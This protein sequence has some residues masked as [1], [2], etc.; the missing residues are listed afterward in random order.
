V[1][2][3][4]GAF[5][6]WRLLGR[7]DMPP[8][9]AVQFSIVPQGGNLLPA[10]G[11]AL[12]VSPSG[13]H[14][15]F[16]G[17]SSAGSQLVVRGLAELSSRP[18]P[19]TEG[20]RTPFF[21]PDG[22][23]V[24]FVADGKLK[25]VALSG[26][27]PRVL[28]DASDRGAT[29][30]GDNQIYFVASPGDTE[31][32]RIAA[33]GGAPEKL[34]PARN[35]QD[36]QRIRSP[37]L[38]PGGDAVLYTDWRGSVE[39]ARIVVQSLRTGERRILFEQALAPQHANG[40]LVFARSDGGSGSL[41]T[42][43]FDLDRLTAGAPVHAQSGVRLN[44]GGDAQYSLAGNGTLA[45]VPAPP[46]RPRS[47]LW[48]DRSG[49]ASPLSRFRRDYRSPRVSPDGSKIA[50]AILEKDNLDIWIHDIDR[51]VST[52]LTQDRGADSTPVWSRDGHWVIFASVRAG[53]RSL[54]RR[55]ADGAGQDE[56]L[57]QSQADH[58]PEAVSPDGDLL[59]YSERTPTGLAWLL[60]SLTGSQTPRGVNAGV[61]SPDGKF[62]LLAT[63]AS[64]FGEAFVGRFAGGPPVQVSNAGGNQPIWSRN[65]REIVYRS[66]S[67]V[68]A[69]EVGSDPSRPGP[70]R[71]LFAD[72]YA[73]S[74][75]LGL[76]RH[77]N[78]DVHPDGRFVFVEGAEDEER[79]A[80][81]VVVNWRGDYGRK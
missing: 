48:V 10:Q 63:G 71:A 30:G 14:L 46:S 3:S 55:R 21:S 19:G 40:E 1:G 33:F 39:T 70:P 13:R 47:L 2:I 80:M 5:A 32:S 65:G 44:A 18:I 36:R 45:Y 37:W 59:A 41:W 51:E 69:V 25:T 66:P 20:A 29:W 60:L 27:E 50:L 38:L 73:R 67:Q 64:L 52:R 23:V 54:Y 79:T 56:R 75:G 6:A 57:T 78:Y 9:P 26:G 76:Q 43:P 58:T 81:N 24:G 74:G 72:P 28:C 34:A 17:G 16:V 22:R 61:F 4:L 42:A 11:L 7:P 62:V 77:A 49:R 31:L 35:S 68:M 12:A 53:A 8:G 15:V